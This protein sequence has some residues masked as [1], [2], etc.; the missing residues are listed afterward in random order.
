MSF[1]LAHAATVQHF[2][3]LAIID[4]DQPTMQCATSP[5]DFFSAPDWGSLAH[6]A[7]HYDLCG[8]GWH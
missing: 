2:G 1:T 3:Y 5:A 6:Y 4:E 7:E 8:C